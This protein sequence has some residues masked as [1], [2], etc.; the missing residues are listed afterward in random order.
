MGAFQRKLLRGIYKKYF[1]AH[2]TNSSYWFTRNFKISFWNSFFRVYVKWRT[3]RRNERLYFKGNTYTLIKISKGFNNLC[4]AQ[5]HFLHKQKLYICIED[6]AE[7]E[8]MSL[9]AYRI[10]FK[11]HTGTSPLQYIN[12][13]RL[14]AACRLLEG[15]NIPVA[16]VSSKLGFTDPYYFSR[17]FKKHMGLSPKQF[18]KSKMV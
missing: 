14:S 9:T 16:L 6:L 11:K 10:F 2:K 18:Q 12:S 1:F 5:I 3:K 17:F 7:L 4:S 15:G 8:Q 13:R